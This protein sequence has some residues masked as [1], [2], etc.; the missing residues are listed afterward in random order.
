[1][2]EGLFKAAAHALR[3]AVQPAGGE[4]VLSTKGVL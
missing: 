1:M 4:G 3:L 2:I